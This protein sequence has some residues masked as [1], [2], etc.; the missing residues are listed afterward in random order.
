MYV[1]IDITMGHVAQAALSATT[2]LVDSSEN[3]AAHLNIKDL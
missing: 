3:T 1:H 2:I